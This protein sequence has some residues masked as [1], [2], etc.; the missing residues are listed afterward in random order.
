M[1]RSERIDENQR[2][3]FSLQRFDRRKAA[4][5]SFLRVLSNFSIVVYSKLTESRQIL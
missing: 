1:K 5:R 4:T 3:C 2:F